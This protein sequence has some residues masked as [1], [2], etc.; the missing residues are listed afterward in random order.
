LHH[1]RK[2]GWY[3]RPTSLIDP[4]CNAPAGYCTLLKRHLV[5]FRHR[6]Y[7]A[8]DGELN[9]NCHSDIHAIDTATG[10]VWLLNAEQSEGEK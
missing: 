4:W 3:R 1:G 7:G 9:V 8:L 6:R 2:P 5:L 10:V